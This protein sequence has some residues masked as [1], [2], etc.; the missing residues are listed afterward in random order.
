[1]R[2][3]RKRLSILMIICSV[4][5][6]LLV[7]LFVNTT[8]N[9]KF[10]NYMTDVQDKRNQRIVSY[11]EELYKS[12][13]KWTKDSGIELMHEAHMGNYCLTLLDAN[14]KPIWAMNPDNIRLNKMPIKDRGVYSVKTFEI[15]SESKVVGYI[16]IGQ[17][18]SLLLSEEDISFKT[19]INKKYYC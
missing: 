5:G 3:I 15:K 10:D 18:S 1:M 17:Y 13:G 6:I 7:T 14:K 2:T 12:Q 16:G 4:A 11:F 9:N 8:I 19:S